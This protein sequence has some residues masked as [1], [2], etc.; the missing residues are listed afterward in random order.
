MQLKMSP[1][2][3]YLCLDAPISPRLNFSHGIWAYYIYV[4][5]ELIKDSKT[6]LRCLPLFSVR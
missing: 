2:V 1:N 6:G 3:A 5:C 4:M